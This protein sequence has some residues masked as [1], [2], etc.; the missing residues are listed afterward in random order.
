[1]YFCIS[2]SKN[3]QL[4][5]FNMNY[6]PYTINLYSIDRKKK[7][8]YLK[9]FLFQMAFPKDYHLLRISLNCYENI[10]TR[11]WGHIEESINKF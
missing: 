9:S 7:I 2:N 1:M 8:F 10:L 3:E 5:Q 4:H 6:Y 11:L